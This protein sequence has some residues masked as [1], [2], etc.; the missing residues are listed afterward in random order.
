[1]SKSAEEA[2]ASPKNR[3]RRRKAGSQA[4]RT[5]IL[6]AA[7]AC[8]LELGFYRASTNEI[9]RR[10]GVSWGSIQYYFGSR[11]RLMLAV[12]EDLNQTFT[13]DIRRAHVQGDTLAERITSLYGILA[14]HYADPS[15]M[16][17]LQIVLNLQHDPDTSDEVSQILA[18][19]AETLATELNRVLEEALGDD[20]PHARRTALF[21]S[22]RGFV[23]SHRLA[24]SV[25]SGRMPGD[26]T[27]TARVFLANVIAAE[28]SAQA[29]AAEA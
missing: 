28:E 17:R 27:E 29:S 2:P 26:E 5:Q 25:S 8:I 18:D 15:Y 9:A 24:D 14:R 22:I 11:E 10:A 21:H 16:A 13:D 1:M 6:Q 12:V 3:S 23:V 7:V 19:Q 4:G 20:A